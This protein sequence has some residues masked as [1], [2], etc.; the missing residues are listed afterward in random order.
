MR[1]TH[2]GRGIGR[3]LLD[4]SEAYARANGCQCLRISVLAR[5]DAARALYQ[6]CGFRERE[7]LFEMSLEGD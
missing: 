6:S 2:R 1:S 5:N 7:V 3:S 4:A